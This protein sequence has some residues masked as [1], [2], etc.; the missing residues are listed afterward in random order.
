LVILHL[1]YHLTFGVV[2]ATAGLGVKIHMIHGHALLLL[3]LLF[4]VH[5]KIMALTE[6]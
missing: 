2:S 4:N 3:F 5:D 6:I 1:A